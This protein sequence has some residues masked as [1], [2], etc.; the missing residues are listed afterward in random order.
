MTSREGENR[1]GLVEEGG[2]L[3]ILLSRTCRSDDMVCRDSTTQYLDGWQEECH[4]YA[5]D[6]DHEMTA[7]GCGSRHQDGVATTQCQICL[8]PTDETGV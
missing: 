7:R 8:L 1:A 6:W 3:S 4:R 2:R 5:W